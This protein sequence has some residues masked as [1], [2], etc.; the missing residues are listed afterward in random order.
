MPQPICFIIQQFSGGFY[1]ELYDDV[2]EIAVKESNALCFRADKILGTKPPLEKIRSSI[3][4]ATI[5]IAEVTP[6]NLNVF[7]EVGWADALEKPTF[8]L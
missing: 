3:R 4:E 8:I 7:Y 2:I 6:N 5:C 1:D